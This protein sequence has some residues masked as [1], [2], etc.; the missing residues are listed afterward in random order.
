MFGALLLALAGL[1]AAHAGAPVLGATP[2]AHTGVLAV[3]HP[4]AAEAGAEMLRRGGNVVDAMA[5]VQFA[6]NVVEPQFSGIGGG[7][8]LMLYLPAISPEPL[9]LDG[10]EVAPAASTADQFLGP[11]GQPLPFGQAHQQGAAVGV[12][13]TLRNVDTA[14]RRFGTRSLAETLEP[15]IALADA[16]FPINRFLASDIASNQQKLASWPATAAVFLPGGHPLQ[17]GAVLRQPDLAR[18]LR[19]IQQQGAD[20]L[21]RGE[22]GQALLEAQAERGGRMTAQ[23]LAAYAVKERSPVVGSYRGYRVFSMPPPSSGG[24]TMQQMLML[25][26]PFELRNSGVATSRTLHLLLEATH[27]AYADRAA[28]MADADFVP[29][30]LHG[31]L[32][33]SYVASRRALIELDHA[34]ASVQAGDPW[35]FEESAAP[36]PAGPISEDGTHTTHFTIVDA[37]GNL[38]AYTT[39]IEQTWGTGT[40]VPGY[41]FLLNNELT[42]FD[43]VPGGPNQVGPGKRPRSSMNPTMVFDDAGPYLALGSPGGA[44][45]STTVTEV[46]L[47]VLEHGLS[48]Q[49]AI[50]A[51][52]IASSMSPSFTW[53]D[54]LTAET[55]NGLRARGHQPAAAPTTIGSVQAVQRGANGEW[56]GGA[57]RRREGTVISVP[58]AS[59]GD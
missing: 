50:D 33:P 52:R 48:L 10:R 20:V 3:S 54:G 2:V 59:A 27:L 42:D 22:V 9:V 37:Q 57:D 18:T 30:P 56:I 49:D 11:N 21:Y 17:E 47:N 24:L 8:F 46:L 40:L 6:L 4:L 15:A 31:L 13:G 14:L 29:V 53:E 32:D 39:T 36:A 25:L 23:D 58:A 7:G 19:L 44:T 43:F 26:E 41:G 38:V 12:P 34:S 16:G 35:A 5:A 45:I 1:P 55:M 51:P 28:Y